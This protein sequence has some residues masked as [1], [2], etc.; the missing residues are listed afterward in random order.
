VANNNT[1]WLFFNRINIE[2]LKSKSMRYAL[3][4]LQ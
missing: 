1:H 4:A 3:R 2:R